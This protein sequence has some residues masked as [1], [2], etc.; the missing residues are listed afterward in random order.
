M[1]GAVNA[2][3]LLGCF[4]VFCCFFLLGCFL[5]FRGLSTVGSVFGSGS[6]PNL[7]DN[8]LTSGYRVRNSSIVR[9]EED[10]GEWE[11]SALPSPSSRS[12]P[13]PGRLFFLFARL[14]LL[15]L[16]FRLPLE[17]LELF[18]PFPFL[19]FCWLDRKLFC[20]LGCSWLLLLAGVPIFFSAG[21]RPFPADCLG[22]SA[23]PL[24]P[25]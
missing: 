4:S 1:V 8:L 7:D 22:V 2:V 11:S 9:P 10:V 3:K 18:R 21:L 14:L 23:T 15:L 16:L 6:S 12:R 24:F 13:P 17:T 20:W 19:V 25:L 5:C